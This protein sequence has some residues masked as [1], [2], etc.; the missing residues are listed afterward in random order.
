MQPKS[1]GKRDKQF[2]ADLM[3]DAET[4]IIAGVREL[5]AQAGVT[6]DDEEILEAMREVRASTR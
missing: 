1:E 5:L 4:R 2:R 3:D 6:A